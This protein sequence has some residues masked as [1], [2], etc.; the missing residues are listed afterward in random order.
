MKLIYDDTGE[1]VKVGDKALT[2]RGE[3]V[4]V[5]AVVKPSHGGSTGRVRVKHLEF[6]K[7]YES[8]FFPGVIG[9]HWVDR[10]DQHTIPLKIVR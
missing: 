1:E 2:F 5:T 10:E 9:A 6:E 8:E 3:E 7:M 4:K